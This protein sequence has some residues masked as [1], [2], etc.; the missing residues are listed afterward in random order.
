MEFVVLLLSLV[1]VPP[2]AAY[3]ALRVFYSPKIEFR[4]AGEQL[5]EPIPIPQAGNRF[6]AVST[7]SSRR[8]ELSEVWVA[9]ESD[10]VD[11]SGT[12]GPETRSTLDTKFPAALFFGA[13]RVVAKRLLQANFFDYKAQTEEFRLRFSAVANVNET[14]L[15]FLLDMFP[16]K[17][18]LVE[19]VVRFR[20]TNDAPQDLIASGL[21][22]KSGE[23]VTI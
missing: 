16:A 12:H 19:R 22:V 4:V 23:S 2:L 15:P 3:V 17:K 21:Q 18:F 7:R 9:F 11:L 10:E 14:D 1:G 6:F 5:G 13:K 8:V 20:V